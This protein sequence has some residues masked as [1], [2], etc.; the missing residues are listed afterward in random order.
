M[1][2][3]YP[4]RDALSHSAVVSS[5]VLLKLLGVSCQM[6][7]EHPGDDL[8]GW[9]KKA[10]GQTDG[11]LRLKR[12]T[13]NTLTASHLPLAYQQH[14]GEF[15]VLARLSDDQ[16]LIQRHHEHAPQV[17]SRTTLQ[18]AWAGKVIQYHESGR[19]FDIRWFIPEFIRHRGLLG[20]ILF[21]SL[22]LQVLALVL[23][24]FFQVIMDKVLVHNALSTLD[25]LVVALVMI[26]LFE[27][28]LK[29]L[30]EY[31][32]AHTT[33]RID[34][35]LGT[36][37]FKHL[38]G[39]P[40]LYF[41]NRH[42]GA[43][44]TR[45]RE[46]DSI[47]NLLTG[48]A[49]TLLVDVSFTF[50]FLGV[51]VYLSAPLT[52]LV[53]ATLPLYALLA[54]ATSE[55][56]K[57]RIE[58]QF[59]C[60]A[61]NTAFLTESLNGVE[62]VK[63]LA[64]EPRFERRW[65][66]QTQELVA[67]NFSRQSFQAQVSQCVTL[68]Q[69]VT[70]V[71]V[72][73]LGAQM[74]MSLELTIGQLIAF[75]MM[76]NHVSQPLAKLV[77]LWQQF[78]QTRVAVDNLS[79][80]LNLPAEQEMG[81]FQPNAPIQGHIEFQQVWFRYQ[82]QLAPVLH[83]LSLTIKPGE[84]IGLVGP[85]GS[86]KSTVTR[87][88]QKLYLAEKGQVLIDGTPLNQWSAAAL[89]QG[90]GV[91]LQEN[92]LFHRTVRENIAIRQP[93]ASFEAVVEAAKLAGAHE[94]IIKMPKGYDTLLAEGGA[95]LSGGQKQRI[96]I[97]RALMTQPRILIFDEATSALDEES[98][99]IVNQN[100]AKIARGRTVITVAHRL[101]AVQGCDRIAVIEQGEVTELGNHQ[102][103]LAQQGCYARLWHIQQNKQVESV[104]EEV[105]PCSQS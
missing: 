26:G 40:L 8:K 75:N 53:I 11:Q 88:I 66:G 45:V 5:Q 28:I 20:E 92:Y 103:L 97:A 47:R 1:V 25:V 41:K 49:L 74:V 70:S 86:G 87:L 100:M 93:T 32:L 35:R 14:D 31:L 94:F 55:P 51:M 77:E 21:F 76:V 60:G 89:R 30:R 64:L 10:S 37:L 13:E 96:A 67:A 73:W 105:L 63:S 27:V 65:E 16:A 17:I 52:A 104:G 7:T 15:V 50:V 38:L 18:E 46:L 83:G 33:T 48:A 44:V 99:R 81:E 79:E 90:I 59:A 84:S 82:P 69:K 54:W 101:S 22:L 72:L 61:Q 102:H 36:K 58:H 2:R 23:P 24:L 56:L 42:V 12:L 98:Q 3:A 91:V 85:S 39:L 4:K 9:L 78:I 6:P 80:M 34:I 95:S 43:I 29:G 62:T 71:G 57:R 19:Q 68:L